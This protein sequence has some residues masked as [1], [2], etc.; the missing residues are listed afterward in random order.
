MFLCCVWIQRFSDSRGVSPTGRLFIIIIK[1]KW[2]WFWILFTAT[3]FEFCFFF[4]FMWF[5][6]AALL[7]CSLCTLGGFSLSSSIWVWGTIVVS[8]GWN[9]TSWLMMLS[10]WS[11]YWAWVGYL[12]NY[13]F[14]PTMWSVIK[15][16]FSLR[17]LKLCHRQRY[18]CTIDCVK[19]LVVRDRMIT[20][21]K[22]PISWL[23]CSCLL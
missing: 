20:H 9:G 10:P 4:V 3:H 23:V 7:C 21:R 5:T 1:A 22:S 18:F 12:R 15:V 11:F 13:D 19:L 14:S 2:L 17:L 6:I 8:S 16:N